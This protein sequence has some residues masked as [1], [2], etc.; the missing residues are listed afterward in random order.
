MIAAALALSLAMSQADETYPG[1]LGPEDEARPHV[2]LMA[3]GGTVLGSGGSGRSSNLLGGEAA[4]AFDSLDVGLAGYGY[5][6]LPD[7]DREWTPVVLARLTQ[8]FRTG[9]DV[10]AAFGFG[11]GAAKPNHWRA[12]YQVA[13]GVRVDLGPV[14]LAGELG[15]EQD[16]LL[17]LAAGL[18][19]RF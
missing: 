14:F 7:A 16:Y 19:A 6:S 5:R 1:N 18:G 11:I 17:R 2:L 8:R 13:L 15:F 9:R 12:W 3:W 10:E 4:W